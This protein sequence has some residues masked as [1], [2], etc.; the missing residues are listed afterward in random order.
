MEHVNK[1]LGRTSKQILWL[2]IFIFAA[3]S[4]QDMTAPE[5]LAELEQTAKSIKDAEFT[6]TGK[7]IDSIEEVEI[8]IEIECQFIRE[9][10]AGRAYFIQ[11]E[12][13]ADN[14][15][16]YDKT[17]IYNYL[18]LTN[19]VTILDATDPDA[20]GSFLDEE[21]KIEDI[22]EELSLD[23]S[24]ETLFQDWEASILSYE[25]TPL[26]KAYRLRFDDTT[27]DNDG[28]D[29]VIAVILE[30]TWTPYQMAW[31][32]QENVLLADLQFNNFKRD[33]GL[34]YEDVVY[35]PEDAEV[36]DER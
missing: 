35:I 19:Q 23:L 27:T 20:L 11:P 2:L 33:T 12:A 26:G 32:Q 21:E 10:E 15:I 16:V 17:F 4:A 8:E 34:N 28:V 6:L 1:T 9:E 7:L 14:V 3:A 13:L 5:I 31:Y 29:Y 22:N 25:D 18:F 24:L 30:E 36:I